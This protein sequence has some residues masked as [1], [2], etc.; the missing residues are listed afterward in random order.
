MKKVLMFYPYH[1]TV[2]NSVSELFPE[3]SF[4][5]AWLP[6]FGIHDVF[7]VSPLESNVKILEYTWKDVEEDNYDFLI[8]SKCI[9]YVMWR[10]WHIPGVSITLNAGDKIVKGCKWNI[11]HTYQTFEGNEH[12][13]TL[14]FQ[15]V[16]KKSVGDWVGTDK[17][18]YFINEKS[19]KEREGKIWDRTF[20][21]YLIQKVPFSTLPGFL[22]RQ[23]YLDYRRMLGVYV[24]LSNRAYNCQFMESM[25]MGQPVVVPDIPDY[26]KIVEHG[27]NGLLYK[28]KE[29]AKDMILFALKDDG[30][31]NEMGKNAY[32]KAESIAGN[33]VRR[34]AWLEVFSKVIK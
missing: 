22:P 10:R 2:I 12:N 6:E 23:E 21:E 3:I 8:V 7:N 25:M 20:Y 30:I 1:A 29:E 11:A 14:I 32:L 24:E 27:K 15:T 34:K 16:G 19:F 9:Y 28:T 17:R 26:N 4:E 13:T 18:A 5:L 31:T 33:E